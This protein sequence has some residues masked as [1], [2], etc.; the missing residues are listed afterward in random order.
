MA[1]FAVWNIG[2]LHALGVFPLEEKVLFGDW[3]QSLTEEI[4]SGPS[5]GLK[6]TKPIAETYN[7][8]LADLDYIRE[9]GNDA[10]PVMIGGLFAHGYLYLENMPC[11]STTAFFKNELGRI[12]D[13]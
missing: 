1:G 7:K 3:S 4:T 8:A 6:T 11:A 9:N 10:Q 13:Y 5:K 12:D 2:F